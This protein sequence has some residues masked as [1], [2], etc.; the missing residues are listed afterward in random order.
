MYRFPVGE[1][2][3]NAL[4]V[5]CYEYGDVCSD[6]TAKDGI[7]PPAAPPV[8]SSG[9]NAPRT[10]RRRVWWAG[11]TCRTCA[12]DRGARS[13]LSSEAG[14]QAAPRPALGVDARTSLTTRAVLCVPGP[15]HTSDCVVQAIVPDFARVKN[16]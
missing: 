6:W 1:R 8:M 7:R 12:V 2:T 4:G 11:R 9:G 15:A 13:P 14:W 5:C 3:W 16:G 10:C